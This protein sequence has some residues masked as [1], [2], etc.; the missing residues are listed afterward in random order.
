MGQV[1]AAIQ[2]ELSGQPWTAPILPIE[3]APNALE[4]A[5]EAVMDV[6]KGD[7]KQG[8]VILRDLVPAT[9]LATLYML[10]RLAYE[11]LWHGTSA[12][13]VLLGKECVEKIVAPAKREALENGSWVSTGDL[14]IAWTLKV[15]PL[16]SVSSI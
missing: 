2:A 6:V 12:K 14:L 11:S 8:E 16:N 15:S 10:L 13:A 5:R 9:W 3:G 4:L 7:F 1:V